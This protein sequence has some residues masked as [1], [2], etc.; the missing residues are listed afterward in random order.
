[1]MHCFD[2]VLNLHMMKFIL[3]ISNELS[4][5]LQR[6]DQDIV[7][8]MDLVRVCR[9]RLQASRDDRWDSLFEE[10]CNF[11]DQHSIDIPNM[12]D[13]FIRFD[14]R[15]RPV[16]KG[17]TLTNLHHYRYDLFC[18]VIDLQLQELGDR[19]SEAST[20]LLLCIACLSSRDS[21]SAFEKKKL[22][23]LAE[24]Y[25]RDFSPLDVCILT[26]Q[27]ESYIFDVR[28]NALFKELNG[29]GDLAEK[30]VKTKKHKVF[31]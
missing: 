12:N 13:T 19:F 22:L 23:R 14:S 25:P 15:G 6:R 1:M 30:L 21:F 10:V 8:A 28:S 16:R 31:P 26:D 5:A 9:Y 11:C 17:P 24:F 2:F 27:L 20:E 29:L 4:H 7:N 3:G 18:D